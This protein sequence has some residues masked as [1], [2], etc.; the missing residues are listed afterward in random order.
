MVARLRWRDGVVGCGGMALWSWRNCAVAV[1]R[2]RRRG[3]LAEAADDRCALVPQ[4]ALRCGGNP[5][6]GVSTPPVVDSRGFPDGLAPWVVD[7]GGMS[8][9]LAP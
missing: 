9:D 5:L 3:G 1:G 4:P 7:S 6:R 8:G 2:W